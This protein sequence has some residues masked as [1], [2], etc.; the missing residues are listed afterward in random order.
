MICLAGDGSIQMNVQELETLV[1]HQLPIKV[2]VFNNA[3][4][5]SMRQTQDNLFAGNRFGE[6]TATGL[7]LPDMVELAR[8]YGIPA[9]RVATHADLSAA[10]DET[11]ASEGPALLDV[12]MDPEQMFSPKVIA[13]KRPD[14]S[15]VSKPLE[16]MFPWLDRDELLENMLIDLYQRDPQERK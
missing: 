14:G 16:D 4:Y 9:R 3:G 12:V 5:V 6:S 2:F 11:L 1:Y 15:L 7:G 13:E 10:I 8:A